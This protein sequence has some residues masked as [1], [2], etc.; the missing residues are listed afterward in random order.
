MEQTVENKYLF[1]TNLE[2][3]E[4]DVIINSIPEKKSSLILSSTTKK[5]LQE[6]VLPYLVLEVGAEVKNYKRGD[7]VY[8]LGNVIGYPHLT[9]VGKTVG[10]VHVSTV[11]SKIKNPNEFIKLYNNRIDNLIAEEKELQERLSLTPEVKKDSVIMT[12]EERR[13]FFK[14]PKN[15]RR[16]TN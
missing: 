13:E 1:D 15:R 5:D 12:D 4:Y 16:E 8:V 2:P 6:E 14:D 7:F 11:L 3:S 10:Q 9:G